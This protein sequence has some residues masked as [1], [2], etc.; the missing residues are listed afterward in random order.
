M[1]VTGEREVTGSPVKE[2]SPPIAHT[3]FATNSY[4]ISCRVC[5][6]NAEGNCGIGELPITPK[7]RMMERTGDNRSTQ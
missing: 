6:Q 4:Q 2:G 3:L 5:L 7:R 1:F